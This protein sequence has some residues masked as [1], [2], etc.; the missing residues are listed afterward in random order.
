[1]SDPNASYLPGT[2]TTTCTASGYKFQRYDGWHFAVNS[3]HTNDNFGTEMASWS[4]KYTVVSWVGSHAQ[5][6]DL[7][8][9]RGASGEYLVEPLTRGLMEA[10]HSNLT[11][12]NWRKPSSVQTLPAFVVTNHIH[13]GDVEP[14]PAS[15][16]F[17]GW[18]KP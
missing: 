5:N 17:P 4:T 13:Y 11:P 14:S 3:G 10:A 2:C 15:D 16:L 18:Y 9:A 12:N 8:A 6:V 7:S 1:M